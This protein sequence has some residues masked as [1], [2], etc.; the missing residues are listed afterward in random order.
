[1]KNTI[2]KKALLTGFRL[3]VVFVMLPILTY[4]CAGV[5]R[6]Q[7]I[8]ETQPRAELRVNKSVRVMEVTGG[9]ETGFEGPIFVGNEDFKAALITTLEKSHLFRGVTT[10][11]G[12]L[13]LYATIRSQ[14][15]LS[16]Q[17]GWE[18]QAKLVVSYKFVD[19]TGREVWVE[20]YESEFGTVA[21]LNAT[22]NQ[23]SRE[24]SVRENLASLVQGISERWPA[25]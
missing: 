25:E 11:S 6:T 21:F 16:M 24:G 19:K 2:K 7:L 14:E 10:N 15:R 18:Y 12:D 13:D 5:D 17:L 4:G 8:P 9:Q 20:T 3:L 1:M 22:R 23:E